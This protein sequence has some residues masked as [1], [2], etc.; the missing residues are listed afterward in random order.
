MSRQRDGI[1]VD[2]SPGAQPLDGI[3]ADF[4]ELEDEARR[5]AER[6]AG[7][8]V[9]SRATL[10]PRL[11][12]VEETFAGLFRWL[13]ER[14]R[15]AERTAAEI[16]LL[17]NDY[18]V[19]EALEQTRRDL[20][21]GFFRQLPALG[22]GPDAG[23]PRIL[24]LARAYLEAVGRPIEL[25]L[26][27]PFLMAYQQVSGLSIGE[28]WA[29]PSVLRLV[30]VES[31]AVHARSIREDGRGG[32]DAGA[33]V[34]AG[35]LALREI[36]AW[37]WKRIFEQVSRV[38]G[39]LRRDPAGAYPAM[40]FETRDRYRKAVEER[41]RW[42]RRDEI[43]VAEAAVA[44][45]RRA[46]TTEPAGAR[47]THVGT[48]L[49]DEGRRSLEEALG[50]RL[51]RRVRLERWLERHATGAYLSALAF[52][53]LA[54]LA[55]PA[56][57]LA[58]AGIPL[59]PSAVLLFFASGPALGLAVATV[60]WL[61]TLTMPPRLLPRMDPESGPASDLRTLVVLPVIVGRVEE[62]ET[63]LERLERHYLGNRHPLFSFGL[64]TDFSDALEASPPEDAELLAAAIAGVRRL[65]RRYGAAGESPFFLLHR[66]R[67][68]NPVEE[69]WMGWER[70]RGKLEELNLLLRGDR[71][72]SFKVAIDLPEPLARVRYVLTLDADTQLLPG[73]AADLVATFD[74]PLNRPRL[75]PETGT[76]IAGF[77]VLQP[78]LTID[79]TSAGRTR[80][81]RVMAGEAGLDLYT[82]AISDAYQDL[83]GEAV[84]A[85]K[86]IYD[87]AAFER[88]LRDRVPENRLL[89]H[90]L[91]EGV[92]GRVGL[93]SDVV[94]LEDF[95]ANPW[96]H[97]RRLHR[98]VRGDWQLLPWLR[99][100]VPTASG[101]AIRSDLSILDRW[102]IVDNLRRSLY[103]PSV[104]ALFL[105]AWLL[106]SGAAAAAA[107][108]GIA[109]LLAAPVVLGALAEVRRGVAGRAWRPAVESAAH[110]V[111]VEAARWALELV[112]LA[113]Q[114]V[115]TIAAAGR[116]LYRVFVSRRKLL[117]WTAA[118]HAE[119]SIGGEAGARFA[120]RE[121]AGAPALAA[122]AAIAVA[123][124]APASLPAAS[125]VLVL[126]LVSPQVAAWVGRPGLPRVRELDASERRELHLIARRTWSFFEDL[127]G[128]GNHWLPPDH[129]QEEPGPIIARRTSPT[130]IGM[131]L[132]STLAAYDLGYLESAELAARLRRTFSSLERLERYRGHWLNW[133]DTRELRPLEPRYV[134]TVDSG[135]L[136]VALLAVGHG[137]AAI[138]R[139][140]TADGGRL[141]G[142]A[143]SVALLGRTVVEAFGTRPSGDERRAVREVA[144][145]LGDLEADLRRGTTASDRGGGTRLAARERL[146][147]IAE[148]LTDLLERAAH[149]PDARGMAA[150][151]TWID[152]A[153]G[154]VGKE[155]AAATASELREL[156]DWAL[157]AVDAMD[158][159]FLY[160][161]SRDLFRIGYRVTS[162]E[163]DPNHYDL[164]ASEA[165][166]AS[167]IAIA[168][169]D[170]PVEHWLHL[171]RPVTRLGG[172]RVLLSWAGTMFEFLMPNLVLRCPRRTLLAESCRAAVARQVAFGRRSGVPWG[173]SESGFAD[174]G[175]DGDYQ[176]RAFG[177][178]GLGLK[179]DLGDRLVVAPY[180]S[181]LA[182]DVAPGEALENLT[183]LAGLGALGRFGFYEAVDFG[184]AR[185]PGPPRIVRSFMAHHQGM[186]LV[187]AAHRLSGPRTVDR[188]HADPR[189]ATVAVLLHE[190]IPK[191]TPTRVRWRASESAAAE[192]GVERAAPAP[193]SYEIPARGPFPRVVPL[194]NGSYTVLVGTGGGGASRWGDIALTRHRADLSAESWGTWIYLRDLDSGDLWSA[195]LEPVPGDPAES[196]A[197][198]AADRVELR[199]RHA[200]ILTRTTVAVTD[201]LAEIR[202]VR[203]SNEGG[204]P[205]RLFV[206]SYAEVVLAPADEDRR[207]PAFS[208]LF[209]ES[210]IRLRERA[211]LFRRRARAPEERS[212]MMGHALVVGR[213][214]RPEIFWETDRDRFLGRGRSRRDPLAMDDPL[215]GFT[216]TTGATLDP[217]ASI[218]R[219]VE[220]GPGESEELAFVSAA[221]PSEAV[222]LR[223]IQ[224]FDSPRR[225]D[226]ALERTRERSE[227]EMYRLEVRGAELQVF[228]ELLS[229]LLA[230]RPEMRA[231]LERATEPVEPVLW[232]RGLSGDLPVLLVRLTE[233]GE[234]DLAL[235][236]LRAQS[237]W[238]SRRTGVDVVLL[239]EVSQGYDQPLRERLEQAV[240][241]SA[242]RSPRGPGR[243]VV[244]RADEDPGAV[245]RLLTAARVVL[246]TGAG[247]LAKQLT[248]AAVRVPE[249]PPFLS[250]S[251][252]LPSAAEVPPLERRTDLL[253]D[254]GLGGFEPTSGDYVIHLE[255]GRRP[256]APWI[257]VV[258]NP[259]FGFL[260]S[261]SGSSCTW[262]RNSGEIRLTPWSNDP[263]TDASGEALYLRDEETGAVW[264]PTPGPAPA[265]A[266]YEVRQEP[267]RARFRLRAKGLEQRLD[268]FVDPAAPVKYALL[269]LRD[270]SN[271]PRRI[272]ATYVAEWVLGG[273]RE[274]TA[275]F[276]VPDIDDESGTLLARVL[277]GPAAG[278]PVAFL[279]ASEP[280]HGWTTDRAEWLGPGADPARPRGLQRIGLSGS[281]RA[282]VDPCAAH[283]VHLDIAAGSEAQ[284]HFVLGIGSD[285]D[286]ALA[287]ARSARRPESTGEALAR[288]TGLWNRT[289]GRIE[290]STPDPGIDRM[291]NRWLPYQAIAC[292]LW[293]RTAFYQSSGAF[294]FRD[295]LQDA[296]NLAP[297]APELAREQVLRAAGHQFV[298][299]DVL[300]W[301][302]A[303]SGFGVRTRCSDDLLWLPWA[304]ARYVEVTGDRSLLDERAPFLAAPELADGEVERFES[305]AE[306]AGDGSVYEHCL[307][308]I[309]RGDTRGRH[310]LPL[311]GSGDWNDGMNRLGEEGRGESIWLAWFLC[312]VLRDFAPLCE[313][314]G[315]PERA[316]ELRARSEEIAAAVEEHGWDGA[317]YRRA[318]ADDGRAIG[319]SGGEECRIDLI[320]Q[321]WSVLSGAGDAER[322]AAAMASV[323]NHLLR[324]EDGLLLLLA[325]PFGRSDLD[326]GYI[327]SYPPGV[328]ENG[329]Q[330]THGA[331]WGAWAFA[332][333]GEGD[334]AVDLLRALLPIEKASM[335]RGVARY[336]VEP[337]A[338]A[339]DV[340]G[341][342]PHTGRGGWTWYTGAAAWLWR[343]GV[344]RVLGLRRRGGE[345]A[346]DPCI[347]RD[348]PGFHA[349]VRV[350]ESIYEI[351]VE[352]PDGVCRGVR[353]VE[354][355]GRRLE[356]PVLPLSDDGRRHRA[357]VVLGS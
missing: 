53:W 185:G 41:A 169:G 319:S 193:A 209:V 129:L 264:S 101:S 294:G 248:R 192:P 125:P 271:R 69:R 121:M 128:P 167:L 300:H 114:S 17:D 160:D 14:P 324:R 50:C 170:A 239:D 261:E 134:S 274:R 267:G 287:R 260:V 33:A 35:V 27:R 56:L 186:I 63:L 227:R 191:A 161:P 120:W 73:A 176:Y 175:L 20:P 95:P 148:S 113:W 43:E 256:P 75:D 240:A 330:Y 146:E 40:S 281:L 32:A 83:L 298:E 86:G 329:G 215:H 224:G 142:P 16:W 254:N 222:V 140:R 277:A 163:P 332:D 199:R 313:L 97:G 349:S 188:V 26:A 315:E 65:N 152:R 333:L 62:I 99:A 138:A 286:E 273:D 122:F 183:R 322:A 200:G 70:K 177:V 259:G 338:A 307:R 57:W 118:A 92:H 85:G 49:V 103:T 288:T 48:W 81:S 156:A 249:L 233:P 98:W 25:E 172:H 155:P 301:W 21:R 311:I 205:R 343:Y 325:P 131:M 78:R 145:R 58:A 223:T 236:V 136:A 66:E 238:R 232:A 341:V 84:F 143:D 308:A 116:T 187:A 9:A 94:F 137:L 36:A 354:L 241:E 235:S 195:G 154:D 216:G 242:A 44:L 255:P 213:E 340:Y 345:L 221:G 283:Q 111:R 45:A 335:E 292:R 304:C 93:V 55:V 314:A 7:R 12:A 4:H 31:L 296:A 71:T 6:H 104:L 178:P 250:M 141:A 105:A 132:L 173:I 326:P 182:L 252:S 280:A 153:L 1:A 23:S 275:P 39:A 279:G 89:S 34:G 323:R 13:A 212:V 334:L 127:V 38:E 201:E 59:A 54:S 30:V 282:G 231:G 64:L 179:R 246:A 284:V 237:W 82:R 207:H 37:D 317:W 269:R 79:P 266:P 88:T 253:L 352:N 272:T 344:E 135:N 46:A 117:E 184:S 244:V 312:T 306:T 328:R 318:F 353:S 257:N 107:T 355:D 106:L 171:G 80:F 258:A 339:A 202:R 293:A 327:R 310:G 162:A 15:P 245:A 18:V 347:A 112:F 336:R 270:L 351:E 174:L 299:G 320:A 180:A 198:V 151:R 225:I 357:V 68:W 285:R 211:L 305:F 289:L 147:D 109:L 67:R 52:L 110:G 247:D 11:A 22:P 226:W 218:G 290:V 204:R 28:L 219:V 210:E 337:Y 243:A 61:I 158:F 10:R 157:E 19:Q 196:S 90:D 263:V 203:L 303:D 268:L 228:C 316:A 346:I 133:Y 220:L 168:K 24:E 234:V 262:W 265:N 96:L 102:K 5:A 356:A 189:V 2:R 214:T 77:T 278:G 229:L 350:G 159:G 297:V 251:G 150:I 197:M 124:I 76:V 119:R 100:R 149:L 276:I 230:P 166:I 348:W 123:A 139:G 87:V 342:P 60:H 302:H 208:K 291:L 3:E 130:N 108:A 165:R 144:R 190:Q 72:T 74:H 181:A 8:L 29:F 51:P 194:S 331:V 42:S 115:V 91:F 47:E 206:A 309:A 295:Q 126:W 321:A 217:I 164:L